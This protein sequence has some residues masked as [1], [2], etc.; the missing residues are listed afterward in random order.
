M[1]SVYRRQSTTAGGNHLG[2]TSFFPVADG[3]LIARAAT[4]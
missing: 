4:V 3:T 1:D 2:I